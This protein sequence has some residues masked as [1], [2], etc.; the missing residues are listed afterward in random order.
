MCLKNKK[1]PRVAEAERAREEMRKVKGVTALEDFD[2]YS[3]LNGKTLQNF[4]LRRYI[5]LLMC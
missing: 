3:E 1:D 4:Q 5:I 2:F